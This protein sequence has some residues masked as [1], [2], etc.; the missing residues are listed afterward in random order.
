MRNYREL[1]AATYPPV[2]QLPGDLLCLIG[3]LGRAVF[4][5]FPPSH[6]HS[7]HTAR[8][9][10]KIAASAIITLARYRRRLLI[11]RSRSLVREWVLPAVAGITPA[12]HSPN[13]R[14]IQPHVPDLP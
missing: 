12:T 9:N 14:R 7:R 4:C 5:P 3:W 10:M 13:N 1:A 8:T 2:G 11:L 6:Q